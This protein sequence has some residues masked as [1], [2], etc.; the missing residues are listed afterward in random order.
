MDVGNPLDRHSSAAWHRQ[1]GGTDNALAF[2]PEAGFVLGVARI[3]GNERLCLQFVHDVFENGFGIVLRIATDGLEL[4]LE[5][6]LRGIHQGDGHGR[7]A[8]GV[9]FGDF[10]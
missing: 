7:F 5:H 10:P 1:V 2:S 3:V 8:Y 4:P 9:G 6:P